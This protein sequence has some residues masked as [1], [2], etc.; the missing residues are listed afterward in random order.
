MYRSSKSI[1]KMKSRIITYLALAVLV[2]QPGAS[3]AINTSDSNA[4]KAGVKYFKSGD[5]ASSAGYL[6][7]AVSGRY[8][9]NSSAH[10][11]YGSALLKQNK[12]EEALHEFATAYGLSPNTSTGANSLKTLKYY[13]QRIKQSKDLNA[14]VKSQLRTEHPSNSYQ[15]EMISPS[16]QLT[17]EEEVDQDKLR[18]VKRELK[19]VVNHSQPGPTL[20]QFSSWPIT[21]QANY[22]YAGAYQAVSQAESNVQS[23]KQQLRQAKARA[24][25]LVPTFRKYGDSDAQF[26][27]RVSA[28]K[29][30]YDDLIRPYQKEV[31]NCSKQLT[32]AIT[33]R[34]RAE[35]ALNT[36]LYYNPFGRPVIYR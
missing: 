7:K 25:R 1:N 6:K 3:L 10:Y 16:I 9:N 32:E 31:Q 5:Y 29:K 35:Q 23:A 15:P 11:W 8:K 27:A 2:A 33:I 22:V 30:V 13:R 34:N 17:A 14:Y 19:P 18:A 36:P 24:H 4:F 26:K 20:S 28:A 21:Q 12:L